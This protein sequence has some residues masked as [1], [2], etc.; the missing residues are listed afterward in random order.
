MAFNF[1]IF[2]WLC[3]FVLD[4]SD[5]FWQMPIHP[6]ELRFFC[7]ML[8]FAGIP[9]YLLFLRTV[10]GSR[11]APLTWARLAAVIMRLTQSLFYGASLRVQ[12]FVDDLIAF[13]LGTLAERRAMMSAMILVWE[14][15]GFDLA[16]HTGQ[17]GSSVVWIGGTVSLTKDGVSGAIKPSI[18]SDILTDPG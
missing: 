8:E 3:L 16:Y 4:F 7:A 1:D 13:L 5:A 17:N 12:C 9:K 2:E 6:N 10:Q 18:V 11:S 14:A 15:L